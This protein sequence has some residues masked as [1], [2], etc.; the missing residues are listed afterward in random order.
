[1]NAPRRITEDEIET[2]MRIAQEQGDDEL[3]SLCERASD[4]D[5]DAMRTVERQL[6]KPRHQ[7]RR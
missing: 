4:G 1:M 2:V 6:Y 3:I 7:G 5:R